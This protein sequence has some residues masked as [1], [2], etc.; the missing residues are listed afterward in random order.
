LYIANTDGSNERQLLTGNNSVFEYHASFSPDG[1][2]ITFTSERAGDGQSDVYRVRTNGS[3][4]EAL[5]A[6]PSFE[7]A[8]AFMILKSCV[9]RLVLSDLGLGLDLS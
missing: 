5:V 6:S 9:A 3:E 4:I 8:G 2:F 1:Q 7:D